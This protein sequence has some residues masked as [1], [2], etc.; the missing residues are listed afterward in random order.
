MVKLVTLYR[1]VE[2]EEK[3]EAFFTGMHLPLAEMLP[4]LRASEVIRIEG[5][6]DG[7]SR[8]HLSYAL[9]FESREALLAALGGPAGVR[10]LQTLAPWIEAGVITWYYGDA[11]AD[12]HRPSTEGTVEAD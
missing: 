12:E 6:P 9:S 4:G 11:W 5:K 2:D 3:L 7:Q 10:L 1:R 8:F